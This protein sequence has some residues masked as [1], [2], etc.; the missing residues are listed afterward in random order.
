MKRASKKQFPYG[1]C[2]CNGET[3]CGGVGP[4]AFAVTRNGKRMHV[5]TRCHL[6]SDTNKKLLLTEK[7]QAKPFL[8]FDALGWFCILDMMVKARGSKKVA[9]AR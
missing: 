8:D 3:C 9:R 2:E 1:V 7:D 4:A 5:C 6:S